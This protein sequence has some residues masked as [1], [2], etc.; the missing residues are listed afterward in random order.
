MLRTFLRQISIYLSFFSFRK[1]KINNQKH[2]SLE[3]LLI[4]KSKNINKKN[5]RLKTHKNLSNE[6]LEVINKFKIKDFL[7]NL[8]IQKI[9]FIHNRA[10]IF[11]ELME[12][13]QDKN[14][15]LWKKVIGENDIGNPIRYFLYP[16][17][18][19]NR[20]RQVFILKK[21]LENKRNFKLKN[22]KDVIEIGGGYGIMT[23]IIKKIN[24]NISYTIY[25][26]YEVNLLQYYY[27]SMNNHKPRLE[28][29]F[30][31]V[32]LIN[33]LSDLNKIIKKK[34]NYLLIANWSISEFPL[35]FRYKF[36]R[37]ISKSECTVIS[38]QENFENINNN[39]FFNKFLKKL[40]KK[41]HFHIEPF[42]HYNKSLL[43]N[44]KHY[45][46]TLIKK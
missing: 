35:K 11:F 18:S 39:I 5:P 2:V 10:F 13:K 8:Y 14:W 7:R 44:N 20:I 42:K 6:I 3:K 12:L 21:V 19:G 17:S 24:K 30:G 41:F 31:K 29:N 34:T 16:Y 22:I 4:K 28:Y 27:L 38:F 15:P 46:L 36:F 32:N 40:K 9:F 23:D 43:N 45:L 1:I 37:A 33:K 26:M 25:D